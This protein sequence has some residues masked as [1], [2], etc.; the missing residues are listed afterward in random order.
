MDLRPADGPDS[1]LRRSH[2]PGEGSRSGRQ[3]RSL[4]RPEEEHDLEARRDG[5]RAH[6]A[7]SSFAAMRQ[8]RQE[9]WEQ[10]SGR[11]TE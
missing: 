7:S 6:V 9:L 1:D 4:R 3:R 10:P 11:V 8:A 2:H 5:Q